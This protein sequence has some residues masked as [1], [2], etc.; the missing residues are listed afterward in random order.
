MNAYP[1]VSIIIPCYNQENV[2]IESIKSCINQT[3]KNIEIIISDDCSND[4]TFET[5]ERFC[6]N[7][8]EGN[9][10]AFRNKV[11]LGVVGNCT[12]VAGLAKGEL[13][14]VAAG[15]DISEP[16]RVE[17]IVN[18]WISGN[19]K[20]SLIWSDFEPI[21]PDGAFLTK[22]IRKRNSGYLIPEDSS[23]PL[24]IVRDHLGVRG[25]TM[26]FVPDVFHR[27]GPLSRHIMTEDAGIPFRAALIGNIAYIDEPLVRWRRG[28][29]STSP[30][31]DRRQRSRWFIGMY[32][33]FIEDTLKT[34]HP[35]KLEIIHHAAR[36]LDYERMNLE[37]A[38]AI[39]LPMLAR[40][41]MA[42]K[43]AV[44]YRRI[45]PLKQIYRAIQG[46]NK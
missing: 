18:R 20:A 17:K 23:A 42:A 5:V 2:I 44:K 37:I 11:N 38:E 35:D 41:R 43:I 26:A 36:Q 6:L 13:I 30:E 4:S 19:R 33:G 9:I 24:V 14:V 28:G 40:V 31:R 3:Y 46:K 22:K 32:M 34:D 15:D 27:F 25:A 12:R 39:R 1:F 16:Q 10:R 45:K 21:G 29:V 7:S 8:K